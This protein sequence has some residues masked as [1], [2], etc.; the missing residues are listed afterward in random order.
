[1]S[2]FDYKGGAQNGHPFK[3]VQ[4]NAIYINESGL[5]CPILRSHL[6]SAR[7]FKRWVTKDVLPSIRKAG[8]YDM[9]HKYNEI[10]SDI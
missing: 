4:R 7:T 2:E 6:E 8:R 9:N 5:Y 1:M 3:N 10:K